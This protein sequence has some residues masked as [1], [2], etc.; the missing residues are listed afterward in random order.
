M[1]GDSNS[2]ATTSS[3]SS[4]HCDR[5][6]GGRG[7]LSALELNVDASIG[8]RTSRGGQVASTGGS[9]RFGRASSSGS[10]AANSRRPCLRKNPSIVGSLLLLLLLRWLNV[11][12][13]MYWLRVGRPKCWG[14]QM[15][16]SL[17]KVFHSKEDRRRTITIV[18]G[19][20]LCCI[21]MPLQS[22][23][24]GRGTGTRRVCSAS[25]VGVWRPIVGLEIRR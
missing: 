1:G 17:I 2:I 24:R 8:A 23:L 9:G 15:S 19:L 18:P 11:T 22:G 10:S 3:L 20:L 25:T 5:L 14:N 6:D 7:S 21:R 12:F 13:G 4:C 16:E